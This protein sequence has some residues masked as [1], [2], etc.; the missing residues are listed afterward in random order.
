MIS[1][2]NPDALIGKHVEAA[3]RVRELG[4]GRRGLRVHARRRRPNHHRALH[5]RHRLPIPGDKPD[6]A[7][8]H[9]T[10]QA[11]TWA[12]SACT[13]TRAAA[14]QRTRLQQR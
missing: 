14:Q 11:I 13:S 8:R 4:L 6:I 9:G 3:T 12:S 1:G 7:S 2:R 10:G 5:E